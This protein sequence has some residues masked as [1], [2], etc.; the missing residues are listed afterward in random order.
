MTKQELL[1]SRKAGFKMLYSIWALV[2]I[3][4]TLELVINNFFLDRYSD[5]FLEHLV[6]ITKNQRSGSYLFFLIGWALAAY[7][8]RNK[9]ISRVLLANCG[10]YMIC[11]LFWQGQYFGL[12]WADYVAMVIKELGVLA[13]ATAAIVLYIPV[14]QEISYRKSPEG[15]AEKERKLILMKESV[16]RE[17][18]AKYK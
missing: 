7:R 8:S 6:I 3:L 12:V 13:N 17:L 5:I 1:K 4:T 18:Q 16:Q 11:E 9:T 10:W 14:L 2:I 15:M